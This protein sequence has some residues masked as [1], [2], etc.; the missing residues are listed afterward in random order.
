MFHGGGGRGGSRG[1]GRGGGRT[2]MD[3][4]VSQQPGIH[5]HQEVDLPLGDRTRGSIPN[6]V[7]FICYF[8]IVLPAL[9]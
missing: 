5:F 7:T 3:D 8:H 2:L 6:V 9:Q 4:F 1:R